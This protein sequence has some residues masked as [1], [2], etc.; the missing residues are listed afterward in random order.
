MCTLYFH[1]KKCPIPRNIH[2]YYDMS[3]SGLKEGDRVH[4]GVVGPGQTAEGVFLRQAFFH[5]GDSL[6]EI[7][8]TSVRAIDFDVWASADVRV[9]PGVVVKIREEEVL[10]PFNDL[11]EFWKLEEGEAAG[12]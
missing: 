8:I 11:V 5:L 4:M 1:G 10:L 3:D 12:G 7:D 9:L 6:K 2:T